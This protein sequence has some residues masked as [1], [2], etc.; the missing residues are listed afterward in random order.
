MSGVLAETDA[1]AVLLILAAFAVIIFF[2]WIL[3]TAVTRTPCPECK[4]RIARG[5]RRCP[6]CQ[7]ELRQA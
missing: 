3:V 4:T 1:G 6:H 5:A 7:A 2:C